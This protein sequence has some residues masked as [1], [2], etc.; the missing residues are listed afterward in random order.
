[1]AASPRKHLGKQGFS[2]RAFA[3][4]LLIVATCGTLAS[5][6][7]LPRARADA[8]AMLLLIAMLCLISRDGESDGD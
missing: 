6:I 5:P 1:M 8:D 2:G 4:G 3:K 7:I